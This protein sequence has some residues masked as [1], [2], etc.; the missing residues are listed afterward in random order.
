MYSSEE[1]K[2]ALRKYIA[3][4]DTNTIDEQ[5]VIDILDEGADRDFDKA[6]QKVKEIRQQYKNNSAIPE[7]LRMLTF[8]LVYDY[9]T[10]EYTKKMEYDNEPENKKKRK[11]YKVISQNKLIE[12][13]GFNKKVFD[14]TSSWNI[15]SP[16]AKWQQ[17][18]Y[19]ALNI[20]M[21]YAEIV[22]NPIYVAMLHHIISESRVVTD[23]FV[24]VFGKMGYVPAICANGYAH[25]IFY[26]QD[27]AAYKRYYDG[28]TKDPNYTYEF[29][30]HYGERAEQ[31]LDEPSE[32]IG[33]D[34]LDEFEA[35]FYDYQAIRLLYGMPELEVGIKKE[36]N[37]EGEEQEEQ[38]K[39]QEQL[40]EEE[41][42]YN[43]KYAALRFIT[44][45]Y[46]MPYWKKNNTKY[47]KLS[48]EYVEKFSSL[49][50][51][52]KVFDIT[53]DSFV[54]YA[55]ALKKTEYREYE[56]NLL[57]DLMTNYNHI[58]GENDVKD[59]IKNIFKLLG[60][61]EK[62]LLFVD[63]PKY[64]EYD[65]YGFDTELL[66]KEVDGKKRSWLSYG[67]KD[68]AQEKEDSIIN[69]L[70]EYSGDWV[71]TLKEYSFGNIDAHKHYNDIIKKMRE[72]HRNCYIYECGNEDHNIS[73]AISFITSI[74]FDE[75][76]ADEFKAKYNIEVSSGRNET[77]TNK[78][79]L[80]K[81][82]I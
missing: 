70:L 48:G 20:P 78:Y 64:D 29:I 57:V 23:T 63:I 28:M 11:V 50:Q 69:F 82:C 77:G 74:N 16:Y 17:S 30:Y 56:D 2:I 36:E 10:I 55:N 65:R 6:S 3:S 72:S 75:L 25:N 26:T 22:S 71:M 39:A 79:R 33:R 80:S 7:W 21:A 31:F 52:K 81:L 60:V 27:A 66:E 68:T 9:M 59:I 47:D 43:S 37:D 5:S 8:R 49:K 32:K 4:T 35:K 38:E 19:N 15:Y 34:R 62:A 61:D 73:T 14:K 76:S 45:C 53:K 51:I 18:Q 44:L 13:I 12:A 67:E 1:I 40:E 42:I 41:K 58:K 24:D 46:Q 54:A